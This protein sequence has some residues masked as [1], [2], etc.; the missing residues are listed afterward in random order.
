MESIALS[1]F[2]VKSPY[3]NPLAKAEIPKGFPK[4]LIEIWSGIM[5]KYLN[6]KPFKLLSTLMPKE[7]VMKYFFL[8]N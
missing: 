2:S 5:H 3:F 4:E 1:C 6:L 8:F 7:M